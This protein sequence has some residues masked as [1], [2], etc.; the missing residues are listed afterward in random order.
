[1]QITPPLNRIP[2]NRPAVRLTWYSRL[3]N[4]IK[5]WQLRCVI[6]KINA[7]IETLE[8]HMQHDKCLAE[9]LVRDYAKSP[10]LHARRAADGMLM[11]LIQQE[12]TEALADLAELEATA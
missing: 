1:M 5:A 2:R 4:S 7:E 10:V 8:L 3:H 9:A 11:Q 12:R 6:A